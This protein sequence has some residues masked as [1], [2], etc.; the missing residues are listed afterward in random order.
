MLLDPPPIDVTHQFIHS[1][2]SSSHSNLTP[3]PPPPPAPPRR[4]DSSRKAGSKEVPTPIEMSRM[5]MT[6]R[7]QAKLSTVREHLVC[8]E[9]RIHHTIRAIDQL[10]TNH[11][12]EFNSDPDSTTIASTP[13]SE[14]DERSHL[15]S[16]LE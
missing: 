1:E 12:G 4:F 3:P 6:Q 8:L 14:H 9:E 11:P 5:Q 10:M 2:D 7:R 13:P 16:E 15:D